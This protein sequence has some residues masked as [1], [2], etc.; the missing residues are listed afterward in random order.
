M[1]KIAHLYIG[2]VALIALGAFLKTGEVWTM[3]AIFGLAGLFAAFWKI[4]TSEIFKL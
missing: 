2:S 4:L 3:L 1:M